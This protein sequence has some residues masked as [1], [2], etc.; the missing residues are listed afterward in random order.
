[1]K[2]R[3]ARFTGLSL[4]ALVIGVGPALA[5]DPVARPLRAGS[6]QAILVLTLQGYRADLERLQH[7]RPAGRVR[8][9]ARLAHSDT[10]ALAVPQMLRASAPRRAVGALA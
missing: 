8:E 9:L 2:Q 1:M 4:A 5:A 6:R 3:I 7:A 10:A